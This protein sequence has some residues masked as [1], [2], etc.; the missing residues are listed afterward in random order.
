VNAKRGSVALRAKLRVAAQWVKT[1]KLVNTKGHQQEP[2]A[3]AAATV[4]PLATLVRIAK[5]QM[6]ATHT[7]LPVQTVEQSPELAPQRTAAVI[8]LMDTRE[9]TVAQ[10]TRVTRTTLPVSMAGQ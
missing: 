4:P 7:T 1:D 8:V 2:P 3:A 5:S 10:Q 9:P 6:H